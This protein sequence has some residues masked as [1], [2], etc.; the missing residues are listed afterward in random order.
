MSGRLHEKTALITGGSRGIGRAT[1]LL[2]ASEGANVVVNYAVRENAANDVVA[3]IREAGGSAI[4]ARADVRDKEQIA[5]MVEAAVARYGGIDI[6]VNNAGILHSGDIESFVDEDLDRMIDVN[7]KGIIHCTRA[8][9]GLM[10]DKGYG[11]I[12]NLSSL[13]GLG[14]AVAGTT[15]YGLT[16]AAVIS[17]TKRMALELGPKG[18]NVNAIC[19]GFIQTDMLAEIA[20]SQEKLAASLGVPASKAMMGRVGQPEDIATAALF[21]ASDEASF[22]TAQALTVDGGRTDFLSHSA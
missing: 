11:K 3:T 13:A 8:V 12:I 10:I 5:A 4:V 20:G 19:P 18:I 22:I 1:A 17:L 15:P 21:L 14:T 2:F 16:K 9:M 6:L 7:V